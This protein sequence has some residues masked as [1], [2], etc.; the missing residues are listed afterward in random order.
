MIKLH[1]TRAYSSFRDRRQVESLYQF[2]SRPRQAFISAIRAETRGGESV[3][4]RSSNGTEAIEV[5]DMSLIKSPEWAIG[6]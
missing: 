4:Y 1:N 2:R 6:L 5:I 3:C